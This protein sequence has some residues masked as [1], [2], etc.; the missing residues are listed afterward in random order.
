MTARRGPTTRTEALENDIRRLKGKI[1]EFE[2]ILMNRDHPVLV[3]FLERLNVRKR[4]IDA[5]LDDFDTK[6]EIQIRLL[7]NERLLVRN[8]TAFD[9]IEQSIPE[10]RQKL[11][12]YQKELDRVKDKP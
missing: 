4:R 9:E 2:T 11:E 10:M 12:S 8:L 3:P 7:L 6:T 1:H 5:D